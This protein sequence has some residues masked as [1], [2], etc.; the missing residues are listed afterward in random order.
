MKIYINIYQNAEGKKVQSQETFSYLEQAQA[1]VLTFV[2]TVEMQ[3]NESEPQGS[4]PEVQEQA[5]KHLM[6]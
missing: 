5:F 6:D 2:D 3:I 1:A 4:A